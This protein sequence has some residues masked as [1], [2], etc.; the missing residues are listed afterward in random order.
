M[1][2]SSM[3]GLLK[4]VRRLEHTFVFNII[5]IIIIIINNFIIIIYLFI[6]S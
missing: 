5:I 6:Y 2:L 3:I 4:I 1:R